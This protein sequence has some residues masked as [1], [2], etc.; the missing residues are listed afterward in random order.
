MSIKTKIF[1]IGIASLMFSFG[2]KS[3]KD[4][5]TTFTQL[6]IS[7]FVVH[8]ASRE[9]DDYFT[10]IQLNPN[11]PDL[12]LAPVPLLT[13]VDIKSASAGAHPTGRT[14]V[15]F[16]LTD[17]SSEVFHS[18]SPIYLDRY[19][20]F[21]WDNRVISEARVFSPLKSK[22]SI[23]VDPVAISDEK[24]HEMIR[25]LSRPVPNTEK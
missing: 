19:L 20:S 18:Q 23:F 4:S 24:L 21:L 6:D 10:Q 17:E 25:V 15:N 1:A 22:M 13:S 12:F 3:T 11:R 5:T 9:R 8:V 2:C 7:R 14:V 16:T